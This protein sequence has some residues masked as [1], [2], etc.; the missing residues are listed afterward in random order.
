MMGGAIMLNANDLRVNRARRTE[1]ERAA[2]RQNTARSN[3]APTRRPSRKAWARI[4]A[5]FF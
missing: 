1:M 4:A 5:L 2:R 3:E